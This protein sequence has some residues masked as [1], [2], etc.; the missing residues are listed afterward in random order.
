MSVVVPAFNE[1]PALRRLLPRLAEGA[2]GR[3]EILVVANGCTDASAEAAHAIGPPVRVLETPVANKHR[4]MRLADAAAGPD[5]FPRF[6][7]DADVELTA[8]DV[9]LLAAALEGGGL[10]A[11][12][13]G[14]RVPLAGCPWTVRWFYDVWLRLPVI[15]AGLFGRGVIGVSEAGHARLSALP[16]LMGDDLA[17]SLAFADHERAVVPAA[18]SVV[19]PPRT[20]RDLIRRRTR[21]VTVTA[22]AG[23]RPE[24]ADAGASARTTSGDLVALLRQRPAMAP[25]I[26]WFTLVT[27]WARHS[28]RHAIAAGDYSTWLRDESSRTAAG[29]ATE[30]GSR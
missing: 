6:Y 12:A 29:P 25:K 28:A 26:A 3:L 16:E 20:L 17:A 10:L 27:L 21:V 24:L 18:T 8:R 11:V 30:S 4:A 7:V 2:R 23:A 14:R 13:P 5:S 15:G 1:A 9:L 22:Q 19:H